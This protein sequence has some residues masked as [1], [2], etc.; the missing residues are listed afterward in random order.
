MNRTTRRGIPV[1]RPL[2]GHYQEPRTEV[3]ACSDGS[4]DTAASRTLTLDRTT[5]P[6]SAASGISRR[7]ASAATQPT[8]CRSEAAE[9]PP[10]RIATL[11]IVET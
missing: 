9:G 11:A 7:S 1:K 6:T 3:Q 4:A 5:P 2:I 8:T 10:T